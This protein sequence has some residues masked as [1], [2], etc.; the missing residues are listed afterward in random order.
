MKEIKKAKEKAEKYLH[1]VI[2]K[3]WNNLVNIEKDKHIPYKWPLQF[4]AHVY[5][6]HKY[7]NFVAEYAI[8]IRNLWLNW[9]KWYESKDEKY[10]RFKFFW[11]ALDEFSVPI[12]H[13]DAQSDQGYEIESHIVMFRAKENLQII[14][15]ETF[16]NEAK[17]RLGD[18]LLE[19]R[20]Y[21]GKKMRILWQIIRSP[22]LSTLLQDYIKTITQ[23]LF[24]ERKINNI[25]RY[26][27]DNSRE[28]FRFLSKIS[29][30]LI[31]SN[32][33][34][35]Y[36]DNAKRILLRLVDMQDEKGS[37]FNDILSTCL[38][39]SAIEILNLDTLKIISERAIDWILNEQTTQGSWPHPQISWS[40]DTPDLDILSTV[41]VL[42]TIDI[43]TNNKVLPLWTEK[44]KI[45]K[46]IIQDR[47]HTRIKTIVPFKT[48]EGINWHDI[49]IRFV[50]EEVVQIRAGSAS[51]GRDFKTMGFEFRDLNRPDLV[52]EA[53]KEFGKH[54][55]EISL[56]DM[57]VDNKIRLNLKYYVYVLKIR[58][59]ELFGI[60]NAPYY[61]YD[62]KK[63]SYKT[64]F[65]IR[66]DI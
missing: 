22:Y 40:H 42:E 54:Q 3:S 19:D 5:L 53:L 21:N 62:R 12:D 57:D 50:S 55:G 10:G 27:N 61:T 49:T 2:N 51:E 24:E 58:L 34:E 17:R 52:W 56:N 32:L 64:K 15:F 29:F 46:P 7:K 36:L 47:N 1:K 43:V 33:K 48:P 25:F 41:L 65:N 4:E 45:P 37:F 20:S 11:P 31:T 38:I 6:G 23:K 35:D 30:F 8:K 26:E 16:F 9:S 44:L 39:I 18:L 59:K 14:G 63:K 60:E 28:D 13:E 66:F